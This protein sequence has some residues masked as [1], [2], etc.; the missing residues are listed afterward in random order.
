M[1]ISPSQPGNDVH[2]YTGHHNLQGGPVHPQG[3]RSTALHVTRVGKE[4]DICQCN[5]VK[6]T[7]LI[8][9]TP[10]REEF[11]AKLSPG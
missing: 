1:T 2:R 7:T 8:H 10:F 4:P 9:K 3:L 5:N 11:F 6:C